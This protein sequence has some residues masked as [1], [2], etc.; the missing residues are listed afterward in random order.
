MNSKRFITNQSPPNDLKIPYSEISK[1][2]KISNCWVSLN[3][4]VYDLTKYR[5]YL[6]DT[7][8]DENITF[9]LNC[10]ENYEG[11]NEQNVLSYGHPYYTNYIIGQVKHY[12][13]YKFLYMFIKLLTLIIM[14]ITYKKTKNK[15]I[16]I[17]LVIFVGYNIKNIYNIYIERQKQTKNTLNK[18]K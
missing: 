18:I 17:I 8:F 14:L 4:N 10:G 16:I 6:K 13:L 3:K 12:Y 11:V 15:V 1:H 9:D 7:I 2:D 5:K